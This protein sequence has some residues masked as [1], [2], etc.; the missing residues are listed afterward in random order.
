MELV[1][2]PFSKLFLTPPPFRIAT[3]VSAAFFKA[4]DTKFPKEHSLYLQKT[5]WESVVFVGLITRSKSDF[6][7]NAFNSSEYS[8]H[9]LF[10]NWLVLLS[11]HLSVLPRVIFIAPSLSV[12]SGTS[13]IIS[14]SRVPS[15]FIMSFPIDS[16]LVPVCDIGITFPFLS[17]DE[18]VYIK[19]VWPSNI[20]LTFSKCER[21]PSLV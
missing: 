11:T 3:S 21:R 7:I 17:F 18:L 16:N 2:F 6:P 10:I 9:K 12:G 4:S 8:F 19:W 13:L 20:A 1:I 14:L 15:D 5:K